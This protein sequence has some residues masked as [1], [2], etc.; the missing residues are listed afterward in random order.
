MSPRVIYEN[1]LVKCQKQN[2]HHNVTISGTLTPRHLFHP[3]V[4][5][6]PPF[7]PDCP[8]STPSG[9]SLPSPPPRHPLLPPPPLFPPLYP[10]PSPAAV[11]GMSEFHSSLFCGHVV[12]KMTAGTCSLRVKRQ[13]PSPPLAKPDL[14]LPPCFLLEFSTKK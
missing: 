5:S 9:P 10:P 8:P 6:L 4:L 12:G 13:Q 2:L 14:L 11:K 7:L 1:N 3:P